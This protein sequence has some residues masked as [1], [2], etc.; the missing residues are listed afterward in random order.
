ML[1]FLNRFMGRNKDLSIHGGEDISAI[2]NKTVETIY[3]CIGKD[4]FRPRKSLNTAMAEAV[5]V[6]IAERVSKELDI[7]C[8]DI[9]RRYEQLVNNEEF[10]TLTRTSTTDEGKVFYR[11]DTTIQVFTNA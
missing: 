8:R 7:E 1:E 4:A 11:L 9:K 10:L 6:G 5:M 2:F 3:D